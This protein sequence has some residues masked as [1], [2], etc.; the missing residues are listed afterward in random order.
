VTLGE[1]MPADGHANTG[2]YNVTGL[3]C[4]NK[5]GDTVT[6]AQ[7]DDDPASGSFH[8]PSGGDVT[9][10][11]TNKRTQANLTLVKKWI[12]GAEGD[13][14]TLTAGQ[15]SMASTVR[16]KASFTDDDHA[17]VTT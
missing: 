10:T 11:F 3:E 5:S 1:V 2:S 16:D 17:V 9:C 15:A 4:V 12:N 13:T 6:V 8:A 7:D 14:A